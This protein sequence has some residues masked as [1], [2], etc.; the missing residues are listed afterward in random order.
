[1]EILKRIREN[2]GGMACCQLSISCCLNTISLCW[3]YHSIISYRTI[4]TRRESGDFGENW[5]ESL[6]N[7]LLST[8]YIMLLGYNKLRRYHI[9]IS[10]IYDI[11][12][13]ILSQHECKVEILG[14]IWGES[15]GNGLLS[16]VHIMMLPEYNKL[17]RYHIIVWYC[18]NKK[19]KW[20]FWG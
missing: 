9:I 20:R 4:I 6:G 8:V 13:T 18:H 15:W 10:S 12:D 16:T 3:R 1:M 7:G 19:G 2:L 17:R 14:D 11:V 5:R